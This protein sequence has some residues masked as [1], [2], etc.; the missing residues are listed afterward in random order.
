MIRIVVA[1][2]ECNTTHGQYFKASKEYLSSLVDGQEWESEL[3]VMGSSECKRSYINDRLPGICSDNP[4][5]FVVFS[6]GNE[7]ACVAGG[8]NY[9]DGSSAGTF[10]KSLFYSTACLNGK[11]LGANLVNGGCMAFVGFTEESNAFCKV[12]EQ[13]TFIRCDLACL[14]SFLGNEGKTLRDAMTDAISYYNMQIDKLD[15]FW[16]V[17]FKGAL[18]ENREAL[19]LLGNKDLKREDLDF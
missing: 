6:H 15:S 14:F 4:F 19:T 17:L 8:A 10:S 5:V 16:D 3:H 1:V 2:D 18:I 7:N 13:E 9:I 12:D 11:E